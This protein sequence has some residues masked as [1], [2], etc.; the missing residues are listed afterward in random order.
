MFC[1]WKLQISK[2][3]NFKVITQKLQD[4]INHIESGNNL[5]EKVQTKALGIDWHKQNDT[6]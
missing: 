1:V 5:D 4:Q 3:A 6:Y 2:C